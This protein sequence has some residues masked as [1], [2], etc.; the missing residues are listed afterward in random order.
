MQ[1]I[2]AIDIE[3]GTIH[4]VVN[5]DPQNKNPES[6]LILQKRGFRVR[7]G[8]HLTPAEKVMR[9]SYSYTYQLIEKVK[10]FIVK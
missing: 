10:L 5:Y 9:V 3:T 8:E 7:Y 1:R 4:T 2:I 6:R